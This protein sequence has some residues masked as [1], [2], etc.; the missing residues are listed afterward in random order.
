MKTIVANYRIVVEKERQDS[1]DVYVA[2]APSLG[3]S[4]FGT[5]VDR[6]IAN[7]EQAITLYLETLVELGEPVPKADTDDYYITT[8]KITFEAPTKLV[9]A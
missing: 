1:K 6:A 4:D 8:R 5:S 7:I 2:Y 9:A 3:L